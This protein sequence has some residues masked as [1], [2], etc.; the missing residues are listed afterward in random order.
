MFKSCPSYPCPLY[1]QTRISRLS[2]GLTGNRPS[3]YSIRSLDSFTFFSMRF[4]RYDEVSSLIPSVPRF[5]HFEV[6]VLSRSFR[7][8]KT[9]HER[10]SST[11]PA[12]RP[13]G[14]AQAVLHSLCFAALCCADFSF[15]LRFRLGRSTWDVRGDLSQ[16][17]HVSLERR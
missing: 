3:V 10:I 15:S 7:T 17:P 1:Y 14:I 6:P 4:S 9:I 2:V 13:Y 5:L 8:L 11:K 16:S 12:S